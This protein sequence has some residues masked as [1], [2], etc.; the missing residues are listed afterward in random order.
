MEETT[1]KR[2]VDVCDEIQ[3]QQFH[4]PRF[5]GLR[6]FANNCF[7]NSITQCLL[8]SPA[9]RHG[10]ENV[11]QHALS[12]DVLRELRIL[13]TRMTNDD[14]STAIFPVECFRAAM[15]TPECTVVRMGLNKRHKDVS[16]F[17]LKLLEH[18]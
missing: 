5:K 16:D 9:A 7:F 10:I 14:P 2:L 3:P 13:F 15:N 6:N 11:P 4:V 17:L 1:K 12:I 18:F 8:H